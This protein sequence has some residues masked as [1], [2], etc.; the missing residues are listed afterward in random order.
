M[1]K[2]TP[3]RKD[4][5]GLKAFVI[6]CLIFVLMIPALMVTSLVYERQNRRDGVIQEV[7]SKWGRAQTIA[8]P[9]LS[10]PFKEY[11]KDSKGV[12][13]EQIN[14]AHFLPHSLEV[15]GELFPTKRNRSLYETVVYNSKL[16]IN[17]HFETLNIQA[18][19]IEKKNFLFENAVLYLGITDPKGISDRLDFRL[20]GE[21]K[22]VGPSLTVQ[23]VVQ[24]GV[25][26]P[27]RWDPEKSVSFQIDTELKGSEFLR[28]IP[29][30]KTTYMTLKSKWPD[31]SFG[32]EFLPHE[33]TI[34]EEGFEA[35]W[36]ILNLN[37]N[38]PQRW[39]S[40]NH[41][42]QDSAFG[43]TLFIEADIYQQT[44]RSVKYAFLFILFTFAAF[45]LCEI[46][47]KAKVHPIQYL[48]IGL[49]LVIFYTLLLSVSEFIPFNKAYWISTMATVSLISLYARSLF[50]QTSAFWV[51]AATLLSLYTCL[52]VLLQLE[53]KALLF[54]SLGLF[55]V[56]T[57]AMYATRK[58]DWYGEKEGQ[59]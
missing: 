36:K 48:L 58:I 50:S 27:L 52:F 47:Y 20:N 16:K 24:S 6:G 1:S 32:G 37:R 35:K 34:T 28:I 43:V 44:M 39:R 22:K 2:E 53:D 55:A 3:Q 31:P 14:F 29:V 30:G 19:G 41:R 5:L 42:I 46:S 51:I 26:I 56:L 33:R 59:D 12:T 13:R 4:T 17:G 15:L 21:L 40:T 57:V 10:I 38:Y 23:E 9:I 7:A 54:G 8:G 11:F 49:A 18:L 25:H 45:F